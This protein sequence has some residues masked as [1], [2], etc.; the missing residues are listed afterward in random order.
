MLTH[1]SVTKKQLHYKKQKKYSLNDDF[2]ED[3]LIV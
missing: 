1:L 3:A 2:I